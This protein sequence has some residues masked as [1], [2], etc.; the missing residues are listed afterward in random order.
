M[1]KIGIYVDGSAPI[2]VATADNP[3][4]WGLVVVQDVVPHEGGNAILARYG[5]AFTDP[6]YIG[7]IG[8][9]VGSNNT[10]NSQRFFTLL[11]RWLM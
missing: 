3:A 7:Y 2:N 8:A 10:V 1:S 4:G 9:E 5:P 6:T 11:L